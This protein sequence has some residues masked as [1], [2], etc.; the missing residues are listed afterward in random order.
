MD[1][2]YYEFTPT[3]V[4]EIDLILTA[5]AVAGRAFHH[6]GDWQTKANYPGQIGDSPEQ[7]IQNAANAAAEAVSNLR[8]R[9]SHGG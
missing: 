5:V 8:N 9:I 2:Y 1:A 4:R 6:T 3:G 7:W